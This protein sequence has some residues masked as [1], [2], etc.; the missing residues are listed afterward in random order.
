MD[1]STHMRL[2]TGSDATAQH[3][4]PNHPH[5]G[6]QHGVGLGLGNWR[7]QCG[8]A[9]GIDALTGIFP[10]GESTHQEVVA[11][12]GQR[13]AEIDADRG[14]A[15]VRNDVTVQG[16]AAQILMFRPRLATGVA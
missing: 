11:A 7:S 13:R 15:G 6:Q 4:R 2:E 8:C 1:Y 10:I 12:G 5:T 16:E 14:V 3:H 9:E